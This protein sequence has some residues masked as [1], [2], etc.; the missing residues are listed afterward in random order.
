MGI[1]KQ[2]ALKLT[3]AELWLLSQNYDAAFTAPE[4]RTDA[5]IRVSDRLKELYRKA[6]K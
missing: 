5:E 1:E 2:Y 3:K 6:R 4:E